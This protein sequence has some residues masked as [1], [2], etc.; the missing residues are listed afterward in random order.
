M[1]HSR[2][3]VGGLLETGHSLLESGAFVEVLLGP[4][5]DPDPRPGTPTTPHKFLRGNEP[6]ACDC[7]PGCT[8]IGRCRTMEHPHPSNV[9]V[10]RRTATPAHLS[11]WLW[12]S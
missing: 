5:R 6:H 12:G 10:P 11:R 1:G 2:A 8:A 4:V 7:G 9:Q 3:F